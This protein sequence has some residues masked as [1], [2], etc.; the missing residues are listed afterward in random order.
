MQDRQLY[1]ELLGLSEPWYV[2]EVRLDPK[3]QEV[4]VTVAV[5]EQ[6]WGCPQCACR[7][8][9]HQWETR[10]WRHLD[11]CQFK[12]L[13]QA[14]VPV[15]QCPE[16]GSQTVVVPWAEKYVRFTKRFERFA[17]DVLRE[18]SVSAACDLLRISWDEADGIKQRAVARGLLRKQAQPVKRMGVDEKCAGRGQDYVTVVARLDSGEPATVEYVGDGRKQEALDGYWQQM[19]AEHRSAVEAVAMDLWEPYFNS[20]MAHVPEAAAKIVHDP[21]HLGRMLS[22]AVDKVRKAEH[23]VLSE[24]GDPRLAGTKYLWLYGWENLPPV[25]QEQFDQLRCQRLKTSRAWAIKETFRDFWVSSTVEE[26][27]EFFG[28]WYSWAIRSRLEPIKRVARSF[29]AHLD[30]ILTYFKH[31]ITN[32]A[33]EGLNNRI[34]GLVKKAFGYRN[35]ERFKTDILFHLGGLDLY[36]SQ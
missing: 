21:Y 35:R 19:T 31:R 25:H 6:V 30:N 7:M 26:G 11:S 15:V 5:R 32:A 14:D 23:R 27:K 16:H 1:Q 17:I 18:C 22:Q 24:A 10:R 36:P 29:K 4:E 8:Q 34:A 12:T 28:R 3:A 9:V 20:T 13:I 2:T 33:L